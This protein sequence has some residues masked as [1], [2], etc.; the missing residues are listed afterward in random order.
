MSKTKRIIQVV[1]LAVVVGSVSYLIA[2]E[3]IHEAR[4]DPA[5]KGSPAVAT[6]VPVDANVQPDHIVAYYFRSNFRCASCFKIE[7]YSKE[8]IEGNFSKELKDGVLSFKVINVDEPE[9]RHFIRDYGLHTK[10]LIVVSYAGDK[11]IKFKNLDRVWDLLGSKEEF[12]DYVKAE[13]TDIL[14]EVEK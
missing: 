9:N 14:K 3:L 2:K 6:A 4:D 5:A 7:T 13:L 12:K 10:S 8:S 11:Q 1:L